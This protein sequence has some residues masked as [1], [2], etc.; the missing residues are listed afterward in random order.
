[1][2][3]G[4][5][6]LSRRASVISPQKQA[7]WR[8]CNTQKHMATIGCC[9]TDDTPTIRSVNTHPYTSARQIPRILSRPKYQ[10]TYT[11]HCNT[12]FV[13]SH[14]GYRNLISLTCPHMPFGPYC[15]IN[16]FADRRVPAPA[17]RL[18][19]ADSCSSHSPCARTD[20]GFVPCS[21]YRKKM[22]E[23]SRSVR[24]S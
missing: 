1:L 21:T 6:W 8:S 4:S 7:W 12:M 16:E 23:V 5:W 18:S 13:I 2:W 9:S 14:T 22:T 11:M 19:A 10:A 20:C 3:L 17:R 15:R 24:I